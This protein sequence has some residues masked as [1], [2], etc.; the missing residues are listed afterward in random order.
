M[1]NL[2][3]LLLILLAFRASAGETDAG[4]L[5]VELAEV[6]TVTHEHFT[7]SGGVWIS[8]PHAIDLARERVAQRKEKELLEQGTTSSALTWLLVGL[9]IGLAGGLAGGLYLGLRK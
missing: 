3:K 9:G 6:D 2:S 8:T 4:I 7:V 5:D 1:R